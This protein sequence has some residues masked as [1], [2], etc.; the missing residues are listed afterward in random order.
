M[1]TKRRI[2]V[3]IYG[4]KTTVVVHTRDDS[5]LWYAEVEAES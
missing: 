1:Q 2:T 4:K 5:G 3:V